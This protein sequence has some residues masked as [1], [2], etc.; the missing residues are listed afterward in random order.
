MKLDHEIISDE[1]LKQFFLKEAVLLCP[2]ARSEDKDV[3]K[4]WIL[5]NRLKRMN[6]LMID[7]C[8]QNFEKNLV[9]MHEVFGFYL[10]EKVVEKKKKH[11][12]NNH[13]LAHTQF[14]ARMTKFSDLI[15]HY[16]LYNLQHLQSLER[17]IHL[18]YSGELKRK[19]REETENTHSTET[20]K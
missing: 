9:E 8:N 19:Q 3:E 15:A 1:E 20:E 5:Y 10:V 17:I 6:R 16:Q 18:Y 13:W 11:A 4:L 12:I 14:L 2:S 7:L